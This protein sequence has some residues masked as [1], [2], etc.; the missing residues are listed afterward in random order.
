[1]QADTGKLL[2]LTDY[3]QGAVVSKTILK[4]RA[5]SVT[6]FAFAEGEGLS[7]HTAPFDA[8]VF[9]LE[10]EVEVGVGDDRHHLEAGDFIRLPANV[11]H[12]LTG[13]TRFKMLLTMIRD[14][15]KSSEDSP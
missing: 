11:P 3:Q 1:M 8:L 13:V 15:V 5:G 6:A 4:Q 2:E 7:E 9:V 10:G 14:M 12:S